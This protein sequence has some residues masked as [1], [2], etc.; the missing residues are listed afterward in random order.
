MRVGEKC[1]PV[2]FVNSRVVEAVPS[3]DKVASKERFMG[4]EKEVFPLKWKTAYTCTCK[5]VSAKTM[6]NLKDNALP[7]KIL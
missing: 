1:T 4:T 5:T 6:K 7:T 2:S 3:K